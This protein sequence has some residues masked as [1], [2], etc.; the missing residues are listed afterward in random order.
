MI[1]D[2][3]IDCIAYCK[4][5]V[6]ENSEKTNDIIEEDSKVQLKPVRSFFSYLGVDL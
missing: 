1:V 4:N 3:C 2:D 5:L 6:S